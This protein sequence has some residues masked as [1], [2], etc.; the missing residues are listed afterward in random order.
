MIKNKVRAIEVVRLVS[1]S[2]SQ[3]DGIY[4]VVN[5]YFLNDFKFLGGRH[6]F[7]RMI[8]R[9]KTIIPVEG[10][11]VEFRFEP[12][13]VW[14]LELFQVYVKHEGKE[15]RFHMN[16]TGDQKFKFAMTDAVPPPYRTLEQSLNDEIFKNCS[17]LK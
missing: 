8:Q 12:M 4:L 6:Y 14:K 5:Y 17:E 16:K 9:F 2:A 10:N 15:R 7:C 11:D 13:N 3:K 1:L